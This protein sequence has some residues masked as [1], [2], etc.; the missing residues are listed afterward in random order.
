VEAEKLYNW[1]DDLKVA[2]EREKGRRF[3]RRRM[4]LT[5]RGIN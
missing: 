1:G 5:G 2:L 3:L 4:E